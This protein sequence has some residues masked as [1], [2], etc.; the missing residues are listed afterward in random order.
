MFVCQAKTYNLLLFVVI[1][2]PIGKSWN[3]YSLSPPN[4]G[5]LGGN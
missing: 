1:L 4:L 3:R 5:D 2:N